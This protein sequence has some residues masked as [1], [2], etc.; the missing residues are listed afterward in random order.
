MA[1]QANQINANDLSQRLPLRNSG[2]ELDYLGMSFNELLGRLDESFERQ[3]RFV[4]DASHQLRTPLTA[5]LG[6]AEVTL[7][8][9]RSTIE[10]RE[11]I[12]RIHA[13]AR[14]LREMVETLLFLARAEG[15]AFQPESQSLDLG[16]WIDEVIAGWAD[17]PR[18]RSI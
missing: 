16:V 9:E 6:Q 2:D 13:E 18:V 3:S 15:E 10:Y 17:H 12:Q 4:R 11:A 5:M 7:R 1:E 14:R 8:R